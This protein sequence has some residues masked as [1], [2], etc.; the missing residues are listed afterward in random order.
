M[1]HEEK[2]ERLKQEAAG[3]IDFLLSL[4]KSQE[5]VEIKIREC[6]ECGHD[7]SEHGE[8]LGRC[9]EWVGDEIKGHLCDCP[10]FTLDAATAMR[11]ACVE[12]VKAVAREMFQEFAAEYKPDG[13]SFSVMKREVVFA[14]QR[15]LLLELESLSIEK[16]ST[17]GEL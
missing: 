6:A 2:Q 12:K 11:S 9:A 14:M 5:A 16:D 3:H 13:T 8:D 4:V 17:T 7:K 1:T 15:R 10:R